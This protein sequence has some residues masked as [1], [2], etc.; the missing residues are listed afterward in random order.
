MKAAPAHSHFL[1]CKGH[2]EF[3]FVAVGDAIQEFLK[4]YQFPPLPYLPSPIRRGV[5]G[6]ERQGER[7]SSV[8]SR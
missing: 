7:N 5:G 6:E 4:V 1:Q 3:F 2:A 8:Q